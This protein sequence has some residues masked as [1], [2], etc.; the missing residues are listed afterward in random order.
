MDTIRDRFEHLKQRLAAIP[1]TPAEIRHLYDELA[2]AASR[3]RLDVADDLT[4]TRLRQQEVEGGFGVREIYFGGRLGG[5]RAAVR[6]NR[7]LLDDI[8]DLIQLEIEVEVWSN[9][10]QQSLRQRFIVALSQRDRELANLLSVGNILVQ[11]I[12]RSVE[13]QT[14]VK[15]ALFEIRDLR[16]RHPEDEI[17]PGAAALVR[18]VN[19]ALDDFQ[20]YLRE[21]GFSPSSL[22]GPGFNWTYCHTATEPLIGDLWNNIG[23][24]RRVEYA[25]IGLLDM[26]NTAED[27]HRSFCQDADEV[28]HRVGRMIDQAW[29]GQTGDLGN[30][31]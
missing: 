16:Q 4:F 24:I 5:D 20:Q 29:D 14:A 27:F 21:L 3:L 31:C 2:E 23:F 28:A 15:A 9:G 8:A 26:R 11:A 22:R 30:N 13:L 7:K 1:E 25:E 19:I 10:L 6:K 12:Q 17:P 18:T